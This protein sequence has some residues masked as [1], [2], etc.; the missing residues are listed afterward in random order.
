MSVA[1]R[2]AGETLEPGAPEMLFEPHPRAVT[3][4][5]AADGQRFLIVSAG[6]EQSPPITLVQNWLAGMK[7]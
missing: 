1:I 7:R 6:T 4:D 3:F 5:A 2:A